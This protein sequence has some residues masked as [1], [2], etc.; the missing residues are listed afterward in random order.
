MKLLIIGDV[1]SQLGR[2]A[3]EENIKKIREEHKIHFIIAN[4]ENTSHGKGLNEGHYKWFLSLGVHVITLGNHSFRNRSIFNFI[5]DAPNIV[6]PYNLREE[7]P[8]KGIVTVNYNGI[9]ISVFQLL[10]QVFM[11]DEVDSPFEKADEILKDLDSDIIICEIHA[12]ATSEKVALGH[13]LD[14]RVQVVYGTHTHVQ[15]NDAK[16]LA[17]GTAYITD[18]GMTGP[19]DSV[20]GVKKDIIIQRFLNIDQQKFTPE[21]DGKY[22]L[23]AIVVEIN[24]KTK[25]V[26][27]IQTIRLES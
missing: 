4:G 5:D 3:L 7:S 13:Y 12:E 26:Q 24:D 2:K 6:R 18:V 15:T 25:Q 17:K 9:K 14:G 1:F 23:N 22:Q 10:G 11:H 21:N 27:S 16:I 19:Y 20:I 8:G